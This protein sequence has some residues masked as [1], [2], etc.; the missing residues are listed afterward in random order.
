MPYINTLSR[1]RLDAGG[2]P[3]SPGELNYHIMEV[4]RQY[5]ED[6]A[7]FPRIRYVNILE[8]IG[9]LECVKLELYRRLAAEYEDLQRLRSGDVTIFLGPQCVDQVA[10]ASPPTTEQR[11]PP[12]P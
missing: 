1:E 6:T 10:L 11:Y 7:E 4:L 12:T 5:M 3:Q 2:R 8:L 9:T